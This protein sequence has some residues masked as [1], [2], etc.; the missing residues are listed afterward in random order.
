M[1]GPSDQ[2]NAEPATLTLAADFPTPSHQEWQEL[3]T[4]VL[5]KLG[6]EFGDVPERALESTT[7]DGITI[8][9][10]YTARDVEGL[11]PAGVP[12]LPPYVRGSR[13]E[14]RRG[15]WDNRTLHTDPDVGA[16][17]AAILT[18]LE[19]GAT[20]VWLRDL[21]PAQL[22]EILHGVYVEM[23][24]VVLDMGE[25]YAE[26]ADAL[27]QLFAERNV[28]DSEVVATFGADPIGL[29]ARTGEP[30]ELRPAAEFAA[31][32]AARYPKA[33][34]TVVDG[35][36]YHEAGG[37]DAQELAAALSAA[38]AYLRAFTEAGLPVE[39][40]AAQL[41]FRFAATADQFLTIAKLRAARRL[42]AR[43]CEVS[44]AVGVPQVQHAVTSSAMVSKRDPYVNMLRG[45]V[46][47][48]AAAV[49]GADAVTVLPFD[50]AIG[51][52]DTFSRRIARN[53][54]TILAEESK[55]AGVIDPAGGSWFVE[56][57]TDDLATAAWREFQELEGLGGIVAALDSGALAERLEATWQ[58][59]AQNLATRKDPLTGVS[60]F[61]DLHERAIERKPLPPARTGGLPS[62]RYGQEFERLRDRADA[63]PG[64]RPRVFLATLGTV[65][66]HTAR[67]TF[68]ANL[69]A[70]GG[71]EAVNPGATSSVADVVAAFLRSHTTVACLCG[72]DLAYQEQADEVAAALRKAGATRILL[73]GKPSDA[74][75]GIDGFVYAGCNALEVLT[76]TL[77]HLEVA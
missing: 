16:T 26:A 10:L 3:V 40:A 71:I 48:F 51:L 15:G 58:A 42:W 50:A 11:P 57:L 69:F 36:P 55:L 72:T 30:H 52:P 60:E 73:A 33:R 13:A 64:G 34:S 67:A 68:A 44:G 5:R 35:T 6:R 20:S 46:A 45:T 12:G 37:S 39:Q 1:T 29:R 49:G 27:L 41:E 77:E 31:R 74:H 24:P 4:G 65:A 14:G 70:A 2:S 22:P 75:Q 53:T 76:A 63:N 32:I 47:C 43:V 17:N 66:Q 61:P 56:K 62:I 21:P 8:K 59:R 25:R 23:A 18:D 7:Y 28:P 19:N 9:P 38:V 54:S